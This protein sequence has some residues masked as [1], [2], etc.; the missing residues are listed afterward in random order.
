[1]RPRSLRLTALVL[2]AASGPFCVPS[3]LYRAT[4]RVFPD[5]ASVVPVQFHMAP[6]FEQESLGGQ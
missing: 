3:T 5:E 4:T 2:P 1:M 6:I